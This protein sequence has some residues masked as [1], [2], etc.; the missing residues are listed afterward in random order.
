MSKRE[1][2]MVEMNGLT[3]EFAYA[4]VGLKGRERTDGEVDRVFVFAGWTIVGDGD[5][6]SLTVVRVGDLDEL[7]TEWGGRTRCAKARLICKG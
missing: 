5:V 3:W 6:D 7:T 2:E 4:E 1:M